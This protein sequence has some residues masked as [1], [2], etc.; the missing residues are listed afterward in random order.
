MNLDAWSQCLKVLA[1]PTRVRLL[2]LLEHEEL[3]VAELASIT[4]LAQPRV[5]TH[6]AKLKEFDL[7]RDRRAGVS[8]YYRFNEKDLE[9]AEISL[10]QALRS[11][12]DDPLLRQDHERMSGVLAQRADDENWPDTVAGDMER[13]YS[14]GRTWEAL[15]RTALPLINPGEILDIASG[16]GVLAE[17]FAPYAKRYV[18]ID[19]SAKVV[20]AAAE[21]L[22]KWPN[23]SVRQADMHVLP[24]EVP[25]FD[26]VLMMHALSY[27]KKPAVA[28]EE[29]ARVL[30]PKGQLLL[31]CLLKHG[32]RGSVEPYGHEN[33]GFSQKELIRFAE[34]AGLKVNHC[35]VVSR[36]RRAPHFEIVMLLAAKA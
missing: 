13:H 33:L 1:D 23:V 32:H 26:L 10:W 24:F 6:L 14:P 36:E 35:E 12:T 5:S 4:G 8:A 3:T 17:L 7:V 31:S 25:Q 30:R 16:D 34:K 18:C 20:Q 22:R 15:A 11:G 28:I 21:R 2:A 9:P 27:S 19:S 29:A